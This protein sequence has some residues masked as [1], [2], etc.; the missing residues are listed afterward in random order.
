MSKA[1]AP[2]KEPPLGSSKG[3][4]DRGQLAGVKSARLATFRDSARSEDGYE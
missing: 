3:G 2:L 1:K 4:S